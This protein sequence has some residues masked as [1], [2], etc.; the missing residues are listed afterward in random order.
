[1]EFAS[2]NFMLMF[3]PIMLSIFY[4]I[5]L[6]IEN[7]NIKNT[8]LKLLLLVASFVFY[9]LAGIK[10]LIVF[11]VCILINYLLGLG[12]KG[13]KKTGG[14][15]FLLVISLIINVLWLAIY[16]YFGLLSTTLL[17]GTFL[18]G[19]AIKIILPLGFSFIIFTQ[20][21]YLV[22]C[23]RGDI[24][25]ETNII[26]YALYSALFVKVTQGPITRYADLGTQIKYSFVD[27]INIITFRKGVK[28]FA[29]GLGK[30]VIIANTLGNVVDQIWSAHESGQVLGSLVAWFGLILYAL[31]IYYD[32][33]GYTDMAIG[34]G[35]MFGFNLPE[36]FDYPYTSFSLKEFCRRWNQSLSFWFRDY[37]FIPL[38]GSRKGLAR[39]IINLAIV[40]I[41]T[42]MWHG[43][44][45]TFIICGGV[46]AVFSI[47]EKVWFGNILEKNPVKIANLLYTLI[48]VVL[49]WVFFRSS[50]LT[51]AF[52]YFKNMFT[53]S[54][55]GN[56]LSITSYLTV[57]LLFA[58]VVAILFTGLLQRPLKKTYLKVQKYN[59]VQVFDIIF[60]LAILTWSI[61]MIIQGSYSPSI[62][63]QF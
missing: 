58:V 22:D 44:D 16:K 15:K 14:K 56:A 13:K 8:I 32:F 12:F 51:S 60:Q 45:L 6:I 30:K 53:F 49:N 1:M 42:G 46:F 10:G 34:L 25:P 55:V 2:I 36:N 7:R 52:G 50:N 9:A 27:N 59:V 61:L 33:S 39:N 24:E 31:Q 54:E 11:I 23:Y 37:L 4:I 62:Y 47:F 21:S 20:I 40:F 41:I 48:I 63:W 29:Y 5:C 38:G 19:P 57:D 26:D 17:K 3:F 28:R 35:R 18:D 43:V